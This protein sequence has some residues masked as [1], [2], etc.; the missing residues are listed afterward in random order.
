MRSLARR[1]CGMCVWITRTDAQMS[2]LAQRWLATGPPPAL[3]GFLRLSFSD[4]MRR[5]GRVYG[6]RLRR[7]RL[8][9]V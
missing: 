6:M 5:H 9:F 4:L 3:Y 1:N 2:E 8:R 7:P